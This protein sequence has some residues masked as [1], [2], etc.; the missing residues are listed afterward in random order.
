MI[1]IAR[2][3]LRPVRRWA[4]RFT[5][6]SDS[7]LLKNLL[8]VHLAAG[9]VC[10]E[11]VPGDYLEF[12][13]FRGNSFVAAYHAIMNAVDDWSSMERAYMAFT[14]TG[15][16]EAA[17]QRVV[18]KRVRFFA[19]DSFDGLPDPTGLDRESARF[20]KGRYDCSQQEFRRILA[21]NKVDESDVVIIPGFYE[22]SLTDDVKKRH[23]LE[24]AAIV[25]IDCD[26]Y[27]STKSVL[28]FI[29]DLL[30]DG[31]IIIFDDWL[32]FR[33]HPERGERRAC[34]EWLSEHP[35]LGLTPFARW[36]LTQQAFVVHRAL[37]GTA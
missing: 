28:R 20:A 31:T 25:M 4:E 6:P 5:L 22:E 26:L 27:S 21:R 7:H 35:E 9:F 16:A 36:G 29:T 13:V 1:P 10:S 32:S 3:L 19:F 12:G 14:D 23:A 11:E 17:F 33:G 34:R 2:R 15:R 37:E 8:P 18:R 30:V 24:A